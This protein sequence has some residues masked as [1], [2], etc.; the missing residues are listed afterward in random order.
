MTRTKKLHNWGECAE[1]LSNKIHFLLVG[2]LES[3]ETS[4]NSFMGEGELSTSFKI[5]R[6]YQVWQQI[7]S[8]QY[9]FKEFQENELIVRIRI[10][11]PSHTETNLCF[12]WCSAGVARPLLSTFIQPIPAPWSSLERRIAR[13][14]KTG[15]FICL[16][17]KGSNIYISG[18]ISRLT[19]NVHI[20]SSVSWWISH[21]D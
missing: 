15:H 10:K 2:G 12:T 6:L 3:L 8:C 19:V 9:R 1:A 18:W 7:N 14:G 11:R 17:F 21:Q 20:F 16:S 13:R 4:S 5:P